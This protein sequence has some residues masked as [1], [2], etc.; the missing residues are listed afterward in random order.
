M[1]DTFVRMLSEVQLLNWLEITAVLTALIYV[2]LASKGNKWCFV[3][4]LISSAVYVYITLKFNLYFDVIIN[5]YYVAMSYFGWI[6]WSNEKDN[7]PLQISHVPKKQLQSFILI[8]FLV[9]LILA[10]LAEY[11]TDAELAYF[12]AFTTTFAIIA[13][14]MVVKK[15]LENWLIWIIVDLV[16]SGMYFYK[17][18]YF[19]SLLF[20]IYTIIAVFGYFKWK[21][22]ITLG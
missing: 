2:F 7:E 3:F 19:T 22:I 10:F 21:R 9:T 11:L 5:I 18:L 4:G 6:S 13:T 14:Y 15:Q 16:A 1:Q 8:G 17:E 12:D 20:L